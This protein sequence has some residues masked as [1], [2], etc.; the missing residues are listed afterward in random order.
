MERN[1]P[2]ATSRKL[3]ECLYEA[4]A[5]ETLQVLCSELGGDLQRAP[6]IPPITSAQLGT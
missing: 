2:W 4:E 1:G 5:I 6:V 3:A